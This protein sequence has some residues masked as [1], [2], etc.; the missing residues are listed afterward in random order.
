GNQLPANP[1]I[2]FTLNNCHTITNL[3]F[4]PK[5]NDGTLLVSFAYD[6]QPMHSFEPKLEVFFNNVETLFPFLPNY[7]IEI[8]TTNT[9]PHSSGIASSAS[10]MA[11]LALC[12]CSMEMEI[13]NT[14]SKENFYQKASTAAR[15]GSGSASRSV[16]GPMALWGKSEVYEQSSDEYAI[17]FKNV[18]EIFKTYCDSILIVDEVEKSVS[19]SVGHSLLKTHPFAEK[20][21]EVANKNLVLLKNALNTGDLELFTQIVEQEAMML[22]AMMMT[23]NP[24]FLLMKPGTVA[25]IQKVWEHRKE[26]GLNMAVTLDAGAN[27]HLLYPFGEKNKVLG[28]I[29]KEL[30]KYCAD[31]QVIHDHLGHGPEQMI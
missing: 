13:G 26:S 7:L 1:S 30:V 23:S 8:N 31:G 3:S 17:E 18:D 9:F 4:A 14:L 5:E 19:S 22:H 6:G 2:S 20:R 25:I 16:Y 27:V 29:N 10:G 24:H 11:A 12:L 15:L 21:Y 28:F